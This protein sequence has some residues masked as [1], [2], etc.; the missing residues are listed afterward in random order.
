MVFFLL[1]G[2]ALR[3]VHDHWE[4]IAL[5]IQ[6]FV[7][8][9]IS[10]LFN[11]VILFSPN[12]DMA[13]FSADILPLTSISPQVEANFSQKTCQVQY[14]LGNITFPNLPAT[15]SLLIH[16]SYTGLL[17]HFRACQENFC[18]MN[19]LPKMFFLRS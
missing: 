12:S 11:T 18:L 3:T 8:K 6:I 17:A 16:S 14:D 19:F 1:Y 2:P 13:H 9:V 10:L 7:G 15:T 4:D 5:T